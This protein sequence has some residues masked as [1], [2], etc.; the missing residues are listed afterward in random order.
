MKR[1]DIL[2]VM[3]PLPRM[4]EIVSEIS[5]AATRDKDRLSFMDGHKIYVEFGPSDRSVGNGY[6]AWDPVE[7]WQSMIC[8][9]EGHL[10]SPC[11]DHELTT[12]REA[13]DA[14]MDEAAR[15]A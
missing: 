14:F 2:E 1:A 3:N 13:I 4:R 15:L 8:K 6:I 11:V 10:H 5:D 7:G 12:L 9:K